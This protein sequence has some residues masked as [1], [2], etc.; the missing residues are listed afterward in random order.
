MLHKLRLVVVL[1]AVL[2]GI[3]EIIAQTPNSAPQQIDIIHQDIELSFD[4][5]KQQA[6]GSTALYMYILQPTSTISL[7]AQQLTIQNIYANNSQQ[8]LF[9]ENNG[10]VVQLD[11]TYAAGD[12]LKLKID[13]HTN[14]VN[15]SDPNFLS[16]SNGQGLRFFQPTKTEPTKKRQIWS[17]CDYGSLPLW[18]PYINNMAD[19]RTTSFTTTIDSS[20]TLITNGH[21]VKATTK[22][23]STTYHYFMNHPY[24]AGSTAFVIGE[25][26]DVRQY[27]GNIQLHNYTYTDEVAATTASV[28]RLPDMVDYFSKTTGVSYPYE[29]YSQVF[30]LDVPWGMAATSMAIQTENMVDDFGTHADFLYLWDGLEGESLAQ[31]WFGNYVSCNDPNHIWL[32]KGFA[33]YFSGLYNA[34]KNGKDE[35]LLWQHAYDQSTYFF[36]WDYSVRQALVNTDTNNIY[37]FI[38][39]NT[40]YFHASAVMRM[41]HKELGETQFKSV[42]QEYLTTYA[43]TSVT[44]ENLITTIEKT[45]RKPI[46]WF[47]DQWVYQTGH[48]IFEVQQD[49]DAENKL[50]TLK[51]KQTQGFDSITTYK[52]T[53]FFKGKMEIAINNKIYEINIEPKKET[54]FIFSMNEKP[55]LVNFDY[56][57]TWLKQVTFEKSLEDLIYQL[58][59]DSDVLGRQSALNALT[60][61][62]QNDTTSLATKE[63]ILSHYREIILSNTYWRF[64]LITLTQLQNILVPWGSTEAVKL[65]EP[66]TNMLLQLIKQDSSWVSAA[67]I[68]FLGLTKNVAYADIYINALQNTSD[69]VVN[70]AAIALGKT[71]SEKA[72]DALANLPSRPSWKN[73]SLMS[74]LS[75][76]KELGDPRGYDI[77]YHALQ[78]VYLS[79]WYLPTP[80]VWDYRVVAVETIVALNRGS[81]VLPLLLTRF[82]NAL[83]EGDINTVF[84]YVVLLSKI[85]DEQIKSVFE[86]L[87]T[88]YQNDSNT[89]VA[90]DTFEQQYLTLIQK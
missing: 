16:G 82:E 36:D 37:N 79:R 72:F 52:Q 64:K 32:N 34:N 77:A 5:E 20:L 38:N 57:S 3:T 85:P 11:R 61:I 68:R 6:Y 75:G 58:Q 1:S 17:A 66:T 71:K 69:R 81:D 29:T 39:S 26:S 60:T 22:G 88:T 78:D 63:N 90:I 80:P 76:L 70:A 21:L 62:A 19:I 50:F 13:Y 40:P 59:F 12:S 4:W 31:Q 46:A 51:V 84:N 45:T 28:E 44:T 2:T 67:A 10:I 18:L 23:S 83:Q 53:T 33:R 49:Y 65:D 42:I 14:W 15:T 89:L 47:F 27:A 30:V 74:A 24:S 43:N 35:F 8:L 87:K 73:Q 9:T 86:K 55:K 7:A 54:N 48:P 56:E 41:L 25:Y